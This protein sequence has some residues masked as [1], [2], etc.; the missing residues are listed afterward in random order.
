ML[1]DL[2]NLILQV[3]SPDIRIYG[4]ECIRTTRLGF[5]HG[6]LRGAEVEADLLAVPVT[7]R[8][9]AAALHGL[10]DFASRVDPQTVASIGRL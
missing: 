2:G 7:G 5:E 6:S 3:C 1:H 4:G 8:D 10:E 9:H